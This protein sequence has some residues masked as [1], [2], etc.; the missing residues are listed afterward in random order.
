MTIIPMRMNIPSFTETSPGMTDQKFTMCK[1]ET[2]I[3]ETGHHAR[4][5]RSG[6]SARWQITE[7]LCSDKWI[8]R[9]EWL[10]V[11]ANHYHL[12]DNDPCGKR[13]TSTCIKGELH[14]HALQVSYLYREK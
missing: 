2:L 1:I 3:Q 7:D 5:Y 4:F 13:C 6:L 9:S 12:R 14:S 8:V 11:S 10:V